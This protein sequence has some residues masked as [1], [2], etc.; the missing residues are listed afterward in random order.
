MPVR[1]S[2]REALQAIPI[3]HMRTG[4]RL[5]TVSSKIDGWALTSRYAICSQD[6]FGSHTRESTTLISGGSF[7]WNLSEVPALVSYRQSCAGK[8]AAHDQTITHHR[9]THSRARLSLV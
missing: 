7:S 9:R 1:C 6:S 3:N 2:T 5:L 4:P 8:G